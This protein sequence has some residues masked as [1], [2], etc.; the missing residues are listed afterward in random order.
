MKNS[1]VFSLLLTLPVLVIAS[2]EW[3][4]ES[5]NTSVAGQLTKSKHSHYCSNESTCPTWFT[6]NLDGRCQ[7]KHSDNDGIICD[8]ERL[9][10]ALLICYCVTY[11][12]ESGSTYTGSCFYNCEF[13]NDI[14]TDDKR[15]VYDLLPQ[16]PKKLINDSACTHFHRRGLLCGDCEEGY[17]PLVLSYNLSCVQCPN[18]QRNW[19]KFIL[20]GFTPVTLF[21][22]F[23]VLFN[24]N[25]TSSRLHGFVWISQMGTMPAFVRIVLLNLETHGNQLA[26]GKFFATLYSYWNLD[27]FHSVLPN[28]CLNVTTLQALALEYLI[29]LYPFILIISSYLTLVLYDREYRF[30]VYVWK[31]FKMLQSKVQRSWDIRTSIIDSFCTFFLLSCVKIL[32]VTCDILIPTQIQK[33]GSNERQF[34]LYYSPSVPYF[35][36]YHLPYAIFAVSIS[37]IFVIIPTI[38]FILYPCQFFQKILSLFPINWHFLH[39]F[40]DSFQGCYKDGTEPGTFDCRWFSVILLIIKP[41][42]FLIFGLT[43]SSMYFVYATV[44][45]TLVMILLINVQPYKKITSKY[46]PTDLMFLFLFS[47]ISIA[48][49]GRDHSDSEMYRCFHRIWVIISLILGFIPAI[50]AGFLIGMWLF[51]RRKWIA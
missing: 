7:C 15:A 16:N 27:F 11:D 48:I 42:H 21:Y 14:N 23:V 28:I 13:F 20:A 31:P 43:L 8:N 2:G 29:A 4:A 10:S 37:T 19:W 3:T 1:S 46:P 39:A 51:S 38:I 25:V 9:F 44:V 45:F 18:G 34:T 49:L 36:E 41:L 50:Y 12:E 32:S 30:L 24:I 6:C 47:L 40:V 33:L 26:V 17:S 5:Q 22:L 35:G